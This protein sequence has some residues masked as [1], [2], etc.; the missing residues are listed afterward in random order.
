M[1]PAR[2][3]QTL[4]AAVVTAFFLFMAWAILLT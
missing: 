4:A 3:T 2:F 1:I